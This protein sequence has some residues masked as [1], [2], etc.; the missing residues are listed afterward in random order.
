MPHA[1]L[2]IFDFD[3]T[4]I[5]DDSLLL[6]IR[7]DQ[8]FFYS[9][10]SLAISAITGC[11]KYFFGLGRGV[12]LK[13]SIKA[14]WLFMIF[15]GR[16]KV[17]FQKNSDSLK[18]AIIWKSDI[19]EKLKDHNKDGYK[20]VIATGALDI[21][22][23]DLLAEIVPYDAVLATKMKISD[24]RLTGEI[25]NCNC[26]RQ[27][28]AK[29]VERYIAENGPFQDIIVYGNHPSDKYMMALGHRSVVVPKKYPI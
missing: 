20:I 1:K 22:I 12:D 26:V 3:E 7:Y 18:K 8:G 21:F 2:A 29:E 28:K 9:Y 5:E 23:Y 25:Q 4:L 10:L 19:L 13:G 11:F 14:D 27:A 17:S 6:F 16:T 15:R 24:G